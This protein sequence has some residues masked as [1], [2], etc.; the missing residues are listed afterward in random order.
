M[1][2]FLGTSLIPQLHFKKAQTLQNI[3][4]HNR[5]RYSY[6]G[7]VSPEE[8]SVVTSHMRALWFQWDPDFM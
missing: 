2:H 4:D 5:M 8:N 6:K 7:Q 1:V 3:M